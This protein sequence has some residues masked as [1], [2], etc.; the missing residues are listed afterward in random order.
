M[1]V[2]ARVPWMC[3]HGCARACVRVGCA[4]ARCSRVARRGGFAEMRVRV[5]RSATMS[6]AGCG[7]TEADGAIF[8]SADGQCLRCN[9]PTP[10][11]VVPTSVSE[12]AREATSAELN[13]QTVAQ[14]KALCR[15]QGVSPTGVKAELV[16]RLCDA[17]CTDGPAAKRPRTEV[18]CRS[19]ALWSG[20]TSE[21]VRRHNSLSCATVCAFSSALFASRA[22]SLTD[23]GATSA[24]VGRLHRRHRPSALSKI[25]PS[26]SVS[27]Q[28][29]QLIVSDR[30]T[31]TRISASRR[32][33]PRENSV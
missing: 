20:F 2:H 32:A 22:A 11:D 7:E 17:L 5:Q 1:T 18:R 30:C 10:A 6:C 19:N 23:V 16:A 4:L 26:A 28:P 21:H 14:L 27:P 29:A 15:Q 9:R 25:A 8:D 12:A 13:A 31:R 24:G 33:V 3:A